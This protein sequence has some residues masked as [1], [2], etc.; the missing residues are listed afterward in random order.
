MITTPTCT[1]SLVNMPDPATKAPVKPSSPWLYV[2]SWMVGVLL[3]FFALTGCQCGGVAILGPAGTGAPS[4]GQDQHSP[5]QGSAASEPGKYQ[6]RGVMMLAFYPDVSGEK[7][8]NA[9]KGSLNGYVVLY[10]KVQ[11]TIIAAWALQDDTCDMAV[12]K[13]GSPSAAR[14][15]DGGVGVFAQVG[16]QRYTFSRKQRET[17]TGP[18]VL[19]NFPTLAKTSFPPEKWVSFSAK[20]EQS[21]PAF[22]LRLKTP[23]KLTIQ[24]PTLNDKGALDTRREEGLFLRWQTQGEM[25][26]VAI[27]LNQIA[28]DG[29]STRTLLCRFSNKGQ[30]M[31]PASLLKAFSSDPEGKRTHLYLAPTTYQLA[32]LPG[33]DKPVLA[34]LRST[35]AVPLQLQ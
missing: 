32:S 24:T 27:R 18:D 11:E 21:Y 29:K 35:T 9:E 19:Y 15:L 33:L 26:Y 5:P 31:L 17:T 12:T 1:Q 3:A 30:G 6:I 23:A 10:P 20:G 7:T 25:P 13:P 2:K 28:T 4:Q 8:L 14:G 22:S 34:V 16:G